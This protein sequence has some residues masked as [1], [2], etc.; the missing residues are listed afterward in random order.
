MHHPQ[1]KQAY[2][3]LFPTHVRRSLCPDQVPYH[4]H[5]AGRIR[6]RRQKPLPLREPLPVDLHVQHHHRHREHPPQN[7]VGCCCWRHEWR[8]LKQ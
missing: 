6:H 1:R 5:L 2:C 7:Q 3:T 4:R 8:R